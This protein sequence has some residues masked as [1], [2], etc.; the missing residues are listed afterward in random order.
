MDTIVDIECNLPGV[1][2]HVTSSGQVYSCMLNQA[3]IELN[4]N[5]F[6]AI[7]I[8]TD[9]SGG[10]YLYSRYGRVGERGRPQHTA[11]STEYAAIREFQKRFR[12]KTGNPWTGDPSKFV[13]KS[14][15]YMLMDTETPDIEVVE[16]GEA[17]EPSK[18]DPRVNDVVSMISDKK[19]M[20]TTMQKFDVDTK[21]LPL[22]KIS[23]LQIVLAHTQLKEI[24]KW[25]EAD[26]SSLRAAGIAEPEKFLDIKLTGLS[27]NFWTL[28]P[29]SCGRN[30]PPVINTPEQVEK[31]VDLLE[32]L[33][34][35]EI[36][37]TIFKRTNNLDDIYD[38]LE[39]EI[40]GV[41]KD[42]DEWNMI[43]KYM[44]NTHAPTHNYNLELLDAFRIDKSAHDEHDRDG[45]FDSLS[46]HRLL[47]HGSRMANYMGILSEG[48][49]IPKPTQVSNG[50][51]L[52][53]GA[54]F[55]DSISKSFNYCQP[56]ETGN[57]GFIVLCEVALGDN[58]HV[59]QH[60]TFDQ[61]PTAGYTS[62]IALGNT[63]PDPGASGEIST[64]STE[65]V[66][67]PYGPLKDATLPT[68]GGSGF[69]YNEFVIYD[70][71]QYRFRYLLKLKSD[72]P[73]SCW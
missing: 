34:N 18:L 3:N 71:R 29:Y 51:V 68:S 28:I 33:E 15:K 2:V 59:V 58:P 14:N 70:S 46:D 36:A 60:A 13:K 45:Y 30:R 72:G 7:Q 11:Y 37:G 41:D 65:K 23:S 27:S 1:K 9:S 16:E 32:V 57:V 67:V 25:V 24:K 22:G 5:K 10:F 19:L 35:L 55:A 12:S 26:R 53:L 8:L 47:I 73:V 17:D 4:N 52:G 6:Y 50:S 40:T 56:G 43:V 48:L 44:T 21:K 66:L 20:T 63:T 31:Y 38:G 42:S 39:A 69:R 49:R 64:A 54:Y 61:R 62:R